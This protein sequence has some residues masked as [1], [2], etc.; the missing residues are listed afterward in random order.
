MYRNLRSADIP[1][2]A[3]GHSDDSTQNLANCNS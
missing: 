1:I 3:S 2:F